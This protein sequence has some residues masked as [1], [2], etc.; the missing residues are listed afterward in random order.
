MLKTDT[1]FCALAV[2]LRL[3]L[4]LRI[5]G[6]VQMWTN[7]E[8]HRKLLAEQFFVTQCLLFLLQLKLATLRAKSSTIQFIFMY[9][10]I[11][12]NFLMRFF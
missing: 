4:L 6:V 1:L 11:K 7:R 9:H 2:V 3:L 5:I 10:F 8:N 12:K